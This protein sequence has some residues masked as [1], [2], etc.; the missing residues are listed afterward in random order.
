MVSMGL[1]SL[2]DTYEARE[3]IMLSISVVRIS[4]FD[5]LQSA[6]MKLKRCLVSG[7]NFVLINLQSSDRIF[8]LTLAERYGAVSLN[9]LNKWRTSWCSGLDNIWSFDPST[10]LEI[11]KESTEDVCFLNKECI[12]LLAALTTAEDWK[13]SKTFS[14]QSWA[15]L[16]TYNQEPRTFMQDY[17]DKL[18]YFS[19]HDISKVG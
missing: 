9:T 16:R 11:L 2:K 12:N 17:P 15:H 19:Y 5:L 8:E 7:E 4:I 10:E 18:I 1:F 14:N 13:D 6:S 3:T